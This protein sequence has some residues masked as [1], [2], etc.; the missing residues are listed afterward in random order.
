VHNI[1]TPK[2]R[3][4]RPFNFQLYGDYTT[5][6]VTWRPNSIHFKSVGGHYPIGNE[7]KENII[8]SYTSNNIVSASG[9]K[10]HISLWLYQGMAP[11]SGTPVEI[12]VKSFQY[13]P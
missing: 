13:T 12:V 3:N 5:H 11:I 2:G 9:V 8:Q 1:T 7:L 6:Y 4:Q 10:A